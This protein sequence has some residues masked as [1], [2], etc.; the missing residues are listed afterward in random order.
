MSSSQL[1]IWALWIGVGLLTVSSIALMFTRWGKN[2]P[3]RKCVV[4]SLLAHLNLLG[5]AWTVQIVAHG[6]ERQIG[7]EMR[8][9]MVEDELLPADQEP[10]SQAA[11]SPWDQPSTRPEIDP[12]VNPQRIE[13]DAEESLPHRANE[14]VV[15]SL[16]EFRSLPQPV[17]PASLLVQQSLP[18]PDLSNTGTSRPA[19]QVETQQPQT[20]QHELNPT[21]DMANAPERVVAN[22]ESVDPNRNAATP[23]STLR[24]VVP[25]LPEQPQAAIT[26]NRDAALRDQALAKANPMAEPAD[27][28]ALEQRHRNNQLSAAAAAQVRNSMDPDELAVHPKM[29]PVRPASNDSHVGP[30][31]LQ[32]TSPLAFRNSLPPAYRLRVAKNRSEIIAERGGSALTEASVK[33]ALAWLGRNQSADGR[34]SAQ[35]H[36]G[37]RETMVNGQDRGGID[38]K[39]DSAITGLALLAFLGDGHTHQRGDYQSQ[40]QKGLDYLIRIQAADGNLSDRATRFAA[41]YCHG[42]ATYALAE[43]YVLSGDERLREP[44]RKAVQ[45]TLAAQSPHDGGW[46]YQRGDVQGDTSQLGWQLLALTSAEA[47]GIEVPQASRDAMVRYLKS[48]SFGNH[49]GLAS[50]KANERGSRPMTAEAL[51]CKLLLGMQRDNLACEEAGNYLLEE[52]P[53]ATARPNYYYWYYGTLSMYQLGGRHWEEWNKALLEQVLSRQRGDGDNAGSWEADSVWGGYGGRV[54]STA[55]ATLSLE[56]YYRFAPMYQTAKRRRAVRV[57]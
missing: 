31:P 29:T 18:A 52:L 45:F 51:F 30:S 47:G 9:T 38:M 46:R 48:V 4:L 15:S 42:M 7:E 27:V 54:Y 44:L 8:V 11:A 21:Q 53:G 12:P 17:A 55:L 34:W 49:Q 13:R 32:N 1:L 28:D 57:R 6:I 37:G 3:L 26:E 39:A 25:R 56:A 19:E 23:D 35:A 43:A 20:A 36:G 16:P 14:V 41:M 2:R 10:Q 5:Y 24:D 40:V 50:Y 33:S 22:A